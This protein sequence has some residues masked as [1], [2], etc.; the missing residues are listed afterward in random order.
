[1]T[2]AQAAAFHDTA[3][4]LAAKGYRTLALAYKSMKETHHTIVK[5]DVTGLVFVGIVAIA[6][7]VRADVK[8]TLVIAKRAGIRVIMITGDH[9]STAKAIGSE[10]GLLEGHEHVCEG[11]DLDTYS[12]HD[13]LDALEQTNVFARVAPEHKI[14][15]VRTLQKQG[16]IVSM[17]GDGVNDAPAI[18]GA[19]IGVAVGSGTDVAKQTAD[20]VLLDDSFT[21]IV[22]AVEEGRGIYQNIK[23]VVLYLL[24]GSFAEVVMIT[25]SILA[26]FPV[27][28]L[29][30]QILWVNII[31]D[32]FPTMALAF[33]KGDRKNMKDPPRKKSEPLIDSEMKTMI[34]IKTIVANVLLFGIFVYFYTTTQ[35]IVL[36]RTIVFVGFA[37]DALFYIF[38]IR[39]LRHMVWQMNPFKNMYLIGAV[40]FGWV[41]LILAVYWGPLQ[42][43]LRTV[44]LNS[45]HW[46]IM[47]CFG[48][49]NLALI[50]IIKG[51]FIVKMQHKKN[52]FQLR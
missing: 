7:P 52:I 13:L 29:P 24:S 32:A 3:S 50:E 40:A 27:A 10:L 39:S 36:T 12:D 8:E 46:V 37:I 21:T 20:M 42:V 4:M 5:D 43:L 6:D 25:G 45:F 38:S 41:M 49:T 9:A 33:D 1:M 14:R 35:D 15:I 51:I 48:V 34:I 30:A 26:G 2:K 11:Q 22:A 19:D 44:P 23:K 31:E 47:I 16:E 28:A 17:T 18:K